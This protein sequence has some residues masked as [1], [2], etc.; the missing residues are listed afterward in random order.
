MWLPGFERRDL[1]P[2]GGPYDDTSR[3][4]I[5]WHTT[6]GSTLAGAEAAYAPYPPH[7]GIDPVRRIKRQ[8][9]SLDRH[10]YAFRGAENDDEFVIQIEVVGFA[11]GTHMWPDS[12]LRWLGEEVVRPI[13]DAVGVP[14]VVVW[15][16]FKGEGDGI[17]LARS[18]SPIRLTSA[19]LRNFSGHL[20]HQHMPAPDEHWDP[21][22]LPVG[23]ILAYSKDYDMQLDDL[24]DTVAITKAGPGKVGHTM[25][26]TQQNA[27]AAAAEARAARAEVAGL[28]VAVEKLAAAVAGD[29]L[30][31]AELQAAV[32]A[33]V[34]E[35][36]AAGI[37]L[38]VGAKAVP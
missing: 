22:A 3:P 18:D 13:R 33:G 20:G 10:S 9:V 11:Q 8:Y 37:E 29:D 12:V 6:Q 4:K 21:G 23:K 1:G 30:T 7:L 28:R 2:D 17:V 19:Q 5:C 38:T 26:N 25:L 14:D 35:A 34:A 24:F 27:A 32:N 15:H 36:L 31:A 16:G